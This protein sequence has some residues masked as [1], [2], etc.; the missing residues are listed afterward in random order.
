MI[1]NGKH[2]RVELYEKQIRIVKT[3]N[4]FVYVNN[5]LAALTFL[6]DNQIM[7]LDV[8]KENDLTISMRWI[9]E[10]KTPDLSC[11]KVRTHLKEKLACYLK[12][13]HSKSY[14][15][16]GY[17]I[18]HEDLFEDNLLICNSTGNIL[19]IDWGLSKN[20]NTVYPDIAS[21]LLGIFNDY[22]MDYKDFLYFYFDMPA[23]IDFFQIEN[24]LDE[25]YQEYKMIRLSNNIEIESLNLRLKNAK[26]IINKLKIVL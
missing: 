13:L 2:A 16:F 11:T 14:N 26:E 12:T 8:R 15:Q 24:F 9:K 18:T 7:D 21:I 3:Y 5:E 19:F 4:N 23:N 22:Y 17:Y 20:R 6:S 10:A 25:R 1:L